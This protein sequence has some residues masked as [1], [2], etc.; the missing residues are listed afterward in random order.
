[1][2]YN[3]DVMTKERIAKKKNER[4]I[5]EQVVQSMENVIIPNIK[6]D[7]DYPKILK[8]KIG[9]QNISRKVYNI[10]INEFVGG[11]EEEMKRSTKLKC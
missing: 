8:T 3:C 6:K 9:D 7:S 11:I 2:L 5:E 1:M 10:V 4:E